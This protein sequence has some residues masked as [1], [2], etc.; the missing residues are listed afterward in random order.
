MHRC[1]NIR[2][3]IA[4]T[5][6]SSRLLP[7]V[8]VGDNVGNNEIISIRSSLS[9]EIWVARSGDGTPCLSAEITSFHGN[10]RL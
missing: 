3:G 5:N 4:L 6:R 1:H 9:P 2:R 10:Y 8:N 7:I